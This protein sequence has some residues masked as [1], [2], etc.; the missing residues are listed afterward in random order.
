MSILERL[1]YQHGRAAKI[2]DHHHGVV[3]GQINGRGEPDMLPLGETTQ[4]QC[5]TCSVLVAI[6]GGD[7]DQELMAL[8]CA[9]AQKKHTNV[10]HAIY[11]IEVPR[12]KPVD[13]EMTA[14]RTQADR[15]LDQ[16]AADGETC[17]I[18]VDKEYIQS[19]NVGQSLVSAAASHGC[20]LMI[21]GLPYKAE[22]EGQL[23][24]NETVDYVIKHAPCRVWVIRGRPPEGEESSSRMQR[25]EPAASARS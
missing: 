1:L 3:G 19:R 23:E 22:A 7:L 10:V 9:V 4:E 15:A 24:M 21:I 5:P 2:G 8:A 11:G 18:T 25:H 6:T 12:T 13:E 16:A 14:E 17:H 20:A